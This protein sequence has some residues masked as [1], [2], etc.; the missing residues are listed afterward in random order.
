MQQQRKH[1]QLLLPLGQSCF[2]CTVYGMLAL[3]A[4]LRLLMLNRS[5][6]QAAAVWLQQPIYCT[7]GKC[8][9]P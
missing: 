1:E 4:L 8:M 2:S 7:Q 9:L 5:Q 6:L 3:L